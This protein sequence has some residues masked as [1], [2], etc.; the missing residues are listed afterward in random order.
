MAFSLDVLFDRKS[1]QEGS[2]RCS[3]RRVI[4]V[5]LDPHNKKEMVE[6]NTEC[7]C[8]I[9]RYHSLASLCGVGGHQGDTLE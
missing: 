9:Q 5:K 7:R 6:Y 1:Y 3:V 2:I 8:N 4:M